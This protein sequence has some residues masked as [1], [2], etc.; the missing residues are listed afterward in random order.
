MGLSLVSKWVGLIIRNEWVFLFLMGSTMAGLSFIIDYMIEI[1]QG[2]G[3]INTELVFHFSNGLKISKNI[4]HVIEKEK[5]LN[6]PT[7]WR[8]F[9]ASQCFLTTKMAPPDGVI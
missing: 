5:K 9:S 1:L 6:F 8:H 2:L 3:K 7:W 4:L